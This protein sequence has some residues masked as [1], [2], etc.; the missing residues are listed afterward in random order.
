MTEAAVRDQPVEVQPLAGK[1]GRS[2][3]DF[4]Y[5]SLDDAVE[6]A[7]SVH[8]L[9]GNQ[10]RLES[11]AADLGH[12]TADSGG[13]R[14]K[15]S[16]AHIFGLTALSQGIVTLST[17]GSRIVDPQQEKAARVEAFLKV[18]LYN[19]IYEQF[20]GGALPPAQGLEAAMVALGVVSTQK[21]KARQAFQKSAKEAG[22]FTYGNTRLV[23]PALSPADLKASQDSNGDSAKENP[24]V[25]GKGS[26]GNDGG[27][28]DNQSLIDGLIRVLPKAGAPF[29][30]E[31]QRRWLQTAAA[32]FAYA[33]NSVDETRYIKVTIESELSSAN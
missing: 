3:I 29:P 12:K 23:Y 8:K 24:A 26:N 17:L 28:G 2:T 6:L 11:L 32:N 10:C 4:P 30:L 9:G 19:S 5:A 21:D 33:Y 22:F 20:K 16:A 7:K 18:P 14:Q 31:A 15:L 25:N 13:F 1:R 27:G